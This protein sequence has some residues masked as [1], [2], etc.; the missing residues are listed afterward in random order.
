MFEIGLDIVSVNKIRESMKKYGDSYLK[1]IFTQSEIDYCSNKARP[2]L[3]FAGTFA[4]KEAVWKALHLP[5]DGAIQWK[6][7]EIK[8]TLN[9]APTVTLNACILEMVCNLPA[10]NLQVSIAHCDEYAIATVLV[11]PQDLK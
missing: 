9:K 1:K 6:S 11:V 7:V 2:E 3:H 8:H 5:G 4:A 10:W